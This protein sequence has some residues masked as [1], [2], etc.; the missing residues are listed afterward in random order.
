MFILEYAKFKNLLE[1]SQITTLGVI[2][3]HCNLFSDSIY[4]DV[5]MKR[6]GY[7]L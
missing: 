3:T 6:S 2:F 5:Q 7:S 4:F 1:Y